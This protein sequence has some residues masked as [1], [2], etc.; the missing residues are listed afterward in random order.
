MHADISDE[1]INAAQERFHSDKMTG[2][3]RLNPPFTADFYVADC[4]KVS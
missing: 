2:R 1:S 3:G 4:T